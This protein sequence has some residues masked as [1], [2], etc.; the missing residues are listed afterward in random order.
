MREG[1]R[2]RAHFVIAS[3]V[4]RWTR[5]EARVSE[6]IDAVAWIEPD[7]LAS[8]LTTPELAD[9]IAGGAAHRER[10]PVRR[11]VAIALCAAVAVAQAGAADGAGGHGRRLLRQRPVP[12]C[13]RYRRSLRRRRLTRRSSCGLPK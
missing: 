6:E 10:E 2:V 13:R 4:G 7:G 9:I 12:R 5:G 1:G 3:F 8:L 11:A